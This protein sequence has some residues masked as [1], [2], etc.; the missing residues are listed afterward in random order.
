MSS[1]RQGKK[2]DYWLL[3]L[4]LGLTFFGLIMV[5]NTSVVNAFRDFQDKY[6]YIRQ[7]AVWAIIG[8]AI[9]FIFSRINYKTLANLSPLLL[10]AVL[11][12]LVAVL[13][14]GI[15]Q[16]ILGAR[17]WIQFGGMTFQPAEATKLAVILYFSYF[18]SKKQYFLPLLPILGLL[19]LLIMM[20][21][22]LGT[23]IVIVV[24]SLSL[25]FA[26][27]IS[28]MSLSLMGLVG[29]LVGTIL[30]FASSYRK[31]RLFTFLDLSQDPLGSSYHIRQILLALGSGGLWGVGLGASRQK[32][33]YLPETMT[34]SIFAIIG[35][36]I[37]FIGGFVLICVFLFLI[38]RGFK[39]AKE[40][41][42]SLSRFIAVGIIS[43]IG[44]QTF[45]NL[46]GMV[47]L[48]PLTGIPLPFISYGGSSLVINLAEI[49]ILLNI[50]QY[51]Q[52]ER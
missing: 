8:F 42:D 38:S 28:L 7:Q 44:I 37:G 14:P 27:G 48:V 4:V 51:G 17:R 31:S 49:G 34:D 40:A 5:Y 15:G 12:S 18:L 43:C 21:P 3:I 20:E 47:A 46:A 25:L 45:V 13:I 41:P 1:K 2:I 19:V 23:T 10:I 11:L 6:F 50:S 22:D 30:I 35:E 24:T 33:E 16:Q 26:A 52:K 29:F 39:I 32:Y 9:M 36:E